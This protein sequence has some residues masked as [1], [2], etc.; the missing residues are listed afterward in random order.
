MVYVTGLLLNTLSIPGASVNTDRNIFVNTNVNIRYATTP[1][2]TGIHLPCHLLIAT[3]INTIN[4]ESNI[5]PPAVIIGESPDGRVC[6]MS[7]FSIYPPNMYIK[8]MLLLSI[9]NAYGFS[10][11]T[12]KSITVL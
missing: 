3:I 8:F 4:T 9:D 10:A 11:G 7:K 2:S 12:I 1:R 5:I 6:V